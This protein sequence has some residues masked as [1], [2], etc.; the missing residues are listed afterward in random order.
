[1]QKQLKIMYHYNSG[2]SIRVGGTLL[3]FDYWEGENRSLAE[4]AR[5][6]AAQLAAYEQ[7]FVFV[8]HAH[9]DHFDPIIYD[10][11]DQAP[12]TYIVSSDL[13]IGKR[14]KRIAPLEEM[15]LSQD[16]RVKAYQSTDLGVAFLVEAYGMKIFHA[17]DLNLWHWRQESTLR[18]IEAAEN[19]FYE[20]CEPIPSGEI[21]LC[22]FPVDPRQGLL[23]D[24]GANHFILTK[25]PRV[26]I[27]MHWQ[28]RKEVAIEFARRAKTPQTE[29]VALTRPG[30]VAGISF[31]EQLLD[32]HI[33][34]P[35]KELGDLPP[36]PVKRPERRDIGGDDPFADTDLPV[37][38]Q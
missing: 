2:F 9:P 13:P 34:E 19:A 12:V 1:M 35:P 28:D 18:E 16:V 20:A 5:L 10:W 29:V 8:S 4:G 32:I 26:F 11:R 25:K 38:I 27:P 31:S 24:A 30:E 6:T 14:G 33:V 23:Y 22:F 36:A 3:V 7:V 17:G 15:E 21:D 37:D